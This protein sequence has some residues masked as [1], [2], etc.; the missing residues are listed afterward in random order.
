[1]KVAILGKI[2]KSEPTEYITKIISLLEKKKVSVFLEF[3]I[4]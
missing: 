4:K 2:N 1:M 3:F